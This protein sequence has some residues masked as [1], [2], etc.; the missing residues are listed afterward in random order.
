MTDED[1]CMLN[2]C[3]SKVNTKFVVF[4]I[5]QCG[6]FSIS[7]L[8]FSIEN[9]TFSNWQ[10]IFQTKLN[11]MDVELRR[12][13]HFLNTAWIIDLWVYSKIMFVEILS[14]V[15]CYSKQDLSKIVPTGSSICYSLFA[16]HEIGFLATLSY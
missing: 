12:K 10:N 14:F 4:S 6:L 7:Y 3:G 15:T 9:E 1:V 8:C 16:T 5:L 2:D 11:E 13:A